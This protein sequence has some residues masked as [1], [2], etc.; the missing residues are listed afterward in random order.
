VLRRA[1]GRHLGEVDVGQASDHT[2]FQLAGIPINGLYTGSTEAGRGARP[3][4][5]CYHLACDT[6]HN[7]NRP[8]LMRMARTTAR[9]LRILS[10]QAK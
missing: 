6:T 10:R 9:A 4:D 2:F 8:V 3:R 7:V 1:A 5:S